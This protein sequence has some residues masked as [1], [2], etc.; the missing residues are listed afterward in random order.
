MIQAFERNVGTCDLMRRQ[1][2]ASGNPTRAIDA[3][4]E[5]RDG[6]TR[7]SVEVS[8]MEME[9]RGLI[10]Q[11]EEGINPKGE[12]FVNQ[13]KPFE[14]SKRE[15]WEAYKRVKSKQGA[16]GVDGVSIEEFEKRLENNLY[17]LWNRMSSGSYF[18]PAVRQVEIPKK[19]G[20]KRPL[21]F[22]QWR[23]AT[24]KW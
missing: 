20:G 11:Q 7:S 24:R 14:I 4:A 23:I 6:Q 3:E 5:H 12:E 15:V 18:P 10:V 13:A 16:A 8:V 19:D 1:K 22:R 17:K 9:R 2:A 21:E